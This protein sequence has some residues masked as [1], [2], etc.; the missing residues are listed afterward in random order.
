[1]CARLKIIYKFPLENFSGMIYNCF[2]K[3]GVIGALRSKVNNRA[4][5][6]LALF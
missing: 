3:K 4:F 1:M 5:I 6:A 2:N